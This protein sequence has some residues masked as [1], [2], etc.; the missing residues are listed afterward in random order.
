[1]FWTFVARD[2]NL[3]DLLIRYPFMGFYLDKNMR[4]GDGANGGEQTTTVA[5]KMLM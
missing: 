5:L 4:I 1:M 2:G 3:F